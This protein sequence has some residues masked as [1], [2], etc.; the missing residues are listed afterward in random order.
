MGS[1]LA[2]LEQVGLLSMLAAAA[3]PESDQLGAALRREQARERARSSPDAVPDYD[4]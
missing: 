2:A 4:F 3:T 1:W